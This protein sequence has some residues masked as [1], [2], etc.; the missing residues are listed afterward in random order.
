MTYV[1]V[2]DEVVLG[3]EIQRSVVHLLVRWCC[4]LRRRRGLLIQKSKRSMMESPCH[5]IVLLVMKRVHLVNVVD[6]SLSPPLV[7]VL[8]TAVS[9]HISST[10]HI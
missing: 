7:T 10:H 9:F 3:C 4:R 5:L 6:A 8:N 1:L 2:I